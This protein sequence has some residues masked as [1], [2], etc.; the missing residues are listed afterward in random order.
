MNISYRQ[1]QCLF[2]YKVLGYIIGG[3]LLYSVGFNVFIMPAHLYNGGFLGLSQLLIW[4]IDTIT[5]LTLSQSNAIGTIY[6][7]LNVPLLYI[8]LKKFGGDFIIKTIFCVVCYSVLLSLVPI[9][10][11]SYLPENI[12]A[13]VTGGILCGIGAGITLLSKGSGGGEEILGLL[14]MQ[15]YPSMSVGKVFTIIN[16][17]VFSACILIYDISA[18]VYSILF[19]AVTALVIDRVHLQNVTMTMMII[20]KKD[21]VEDLVFN[22]VHRGVTTIQGTGAYSGE[23]THILLTVVAKNEALVLRKVLA[24][25]DPDV[26]IIEDESIN[27]IGNFKKRL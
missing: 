9:P 13:A 14:L 25:Y 3:S 19:A 1:L 6:F 7:L 24:E 2:D 16:V 20:T 27:V 11:H 10:D 23:P 26:F 8:S 22:T 15:K 18:G 5:G 17:F 4:F 21:G 12:T